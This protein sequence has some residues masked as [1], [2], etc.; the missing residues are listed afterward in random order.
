MSFVDEIA[1]RHGI[2]KRSVVFQYMVRKTKASDRGS[3]AR[4]SLGNLYALYVLAEDYLNENHEG[5][6]FTDL[7]ARMKALPF[8]SKLQNHPLD[9]RLNDEVQRQYGVGEEMLPVQAA[10]LGDGKKAR[11]IS[12]DLL[13]EGG[14]DPMATATFIVGTIDAYVSIIG[15]NQTT[16]LG[17]IEAASSSEEISEIIKKAFEYA[18]DARLFEIVSFAL[19]HIKYKSQSVTVSANGQDATYQLTLFKTGRTNANDGG[20]DFVLKPYGRFFQVTETL[21]FNKYFLDF[22]KTNRFPI[23]FVIKT[24]LRPDQVMEQ[25]RSDANKTYP[26]DEVEGYLG[27]FEEVITINELTSVL[28]EIRE[29]P[30][31]IEELKALVINEFKLEFGMLD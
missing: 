16:Y 8:G 19:L 26:E 15:E 7:M 6:R 3:K 2:E 25:I 10:D 24:T 18:S 12:T 5:S 22:D 11:K 21:N 13:S 23:T 28:D 29:S 17:E 31:L 20:I 9:N 14:A 4:R 27:L 1:E 30:E